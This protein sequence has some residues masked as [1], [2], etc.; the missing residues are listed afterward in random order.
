[1]IAQARGQQN[2]LCTLS[3]GGL[4]R[5]SSICSKRAR[6][7]CGALLIRRRSTSHQGARLLKL[8][9][10]PL[11]RQQELLLL[12]TLGP[13]L[14]SMKGYGAPEVEQTYARAYELCHRRSPVSL[15][16]CAGP[17][18]LLSRA[19]EVRKVQDLADKPSSG[20]EHLTPTPSWLPRNAWDIMGITWRVDAAREHVEAWGLYKPQ[21]HNSR[22]TR[23]W[24]DLVLYLSYAAAPCGIWAIQTKHWRS[25]AP[26]A[27]RPRMAHPFSSVHFGVGC[28]FAFFPW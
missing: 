16:V 11:A 7:R 10:M 6:M 4:R 25:A 27:A 13:A 19:G 14:I 23:S 28:S 5:Q 21:K 26:P 1:V 12:T 9:R 15:S 2:W 8:Y 18:G 22:V 3:R 17:P 20:S 24:G